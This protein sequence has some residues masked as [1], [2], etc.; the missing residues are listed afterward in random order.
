MEHNTNRNDTPLNFEEFAY[1]SFIIL[2]LMVSSSCALLSLLS[3]MQLTEF[4][5]P[6]LT[7]VMGMS[8]ENAPLFG[9]AWC[10]LIALYAGTIVYRDMDAKRFL[11]MIK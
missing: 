2:T 9:V 3:Y 7:N 10:S 4:S 5:H 11:S 6:L 1:C 8:I